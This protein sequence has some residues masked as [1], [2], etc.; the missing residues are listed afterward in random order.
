MNQL[1]Q[2][3]LAGGYHFC[4]DSD[5]V[6]LDQIEYVTQNIAGYAQYP[7]M[8]VRQSDAIREKGFADYTSRRA[9]ITS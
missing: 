4:I 5:C 3:K 7:V 9:L 6:L 1:V 2:Q 8:I